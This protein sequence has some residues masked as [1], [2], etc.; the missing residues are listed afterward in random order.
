MCRISTTTDVACIFL[1]VQTV[2]GLTAAGVHL[3]QAIAA[4]HMQIFDPKRFEARQN[5][6]QQQIKEIE[7]I[8]AHD[9]SSEHWKSR[10]ISILEYQKD[11]CLASLYRCCTSLIQSIPVVGTGYSLYVYNTSTVHISHFEGGGCG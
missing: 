10:Q 5:F 11:S 9:Y 4:L 7:D 3:L 2:V 1:G 6:K 8:E